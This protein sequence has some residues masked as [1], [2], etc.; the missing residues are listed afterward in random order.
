MFWFFS[1]AHCVAP[2]LAMPSKSAVVHPF[3]PFS[4]PIL[5]QSHSKV[6]LCDTSPFL[7]LNKIFS[8]PS[9]SGVVGKG[10][11]KEALKHPHYPS[12]LFLER[13]K[14]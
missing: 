9:N 10:M 13:K 3:Q 11:K 8:L 1:L 7:I 5:L 2:A 14:I 6:F 4:L 12:C